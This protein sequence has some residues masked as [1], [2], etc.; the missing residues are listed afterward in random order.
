MPGVW[1]GLAPGAAWRGVRD[2]GGAREDGREQLEPA[3]SGVGVGPVTPE[4]DLESNRSI[5]NRYL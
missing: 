4:A 3:R 1:S 5:D 2:F